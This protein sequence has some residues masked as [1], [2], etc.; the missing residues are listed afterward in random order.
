[1]AGVTGDIHVA[2]VSTKLIF[3]GRKPFEK[4]NT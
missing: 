3:E 2:S 4:C 1:M